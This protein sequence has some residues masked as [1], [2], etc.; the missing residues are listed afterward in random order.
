[1]EK[2]RGVS[3]MIGWAW[4]VESTIGVGPH[5]RE[6][7]SSIEITETLDASAKEKRNETVIPMCEKENETMTEVIET[8]SPPRPTCS[9]ATLI[10]SDAGTS[11]N[12]VQAPMINSVKCAKIKSNDVT[13]EI[14]YWKS[15]IL[16]SVLGANAPLEV[17]EGFIGRI[18]EAY[19]IDKI[20]WVRKG[21]YLPKQDWKLARHSHKDWQIYQGE[22]N[23]KYARLLIEMQVDDDFLDFIEIINEHNVVM[24][25]KVEYGWKPIRCSH[26]I[27][28]RHCEEE[29]RKKSQL[30]TE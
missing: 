15:S 11:L 4:N 26:C 12:F 1:M 22:I 23:A 20:C 21:V 29:C 18:W 17:I 8:R 10:D 7:A 3:D 30:R 25:R 5:R 2:I 19:D 14:D 9:Y 24:R 27:M 6:D 16:C 28:Y 13:P